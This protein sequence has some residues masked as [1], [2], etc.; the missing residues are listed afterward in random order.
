[1]KKKNGE[2]DLK[3]IEENFKER[4]KLFTNMEKNIEIH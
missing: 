4:Q 2:K 3:I 1:M